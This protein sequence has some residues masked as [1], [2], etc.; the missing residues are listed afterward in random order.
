MLS[1]NDDEKSSSGAGVYNGGKTDVKCYG[2]Q[3][4]EKYVLTMTLGFMVIVP[5]ILPNPASSPH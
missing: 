4:E 5:I 3:I 1:S 2:W